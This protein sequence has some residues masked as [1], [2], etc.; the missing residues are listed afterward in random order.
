MDKDYKLKWSME[1]AKAHTYVDGS[2]TVSLF[3]MNGSKY[4]EQGFR[5]LEQAEKWLR[6]AW[7]EF[8]G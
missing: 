4:H 8:I 5:T 1:T 7:G 2:C 6:N 3:D